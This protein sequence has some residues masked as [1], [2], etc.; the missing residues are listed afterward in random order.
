MKRALVVLAILLAVLGAGLAWRNARTVDRLDRRFTADTLAAADRR[1]LS[2]ARR[3]KAAYGGRVWPGLGRAHIPQVLYDDRWEFLAGWAGPAPEGWERAGDA[4]LF[5]V[6]IRRRRARDP[7][8]FALEVEDR[9]V[10]RY[11]VR[12]LLDRL[13]VQEARRGMDPVSAALV[14]PDLSTVPPDLYVV[15]LLHTAFHAFQATRSEDRF[16][17]AVEL[18]RR[19]ADRYPFGD[20]AISEL[21]TRE[22]A[23]LGRILAAGQRA[24]AC[25]AVEAFRS[26][27]ARRRGRAVLDSALVAYERAQEWLQGTAKYAELAFYRRAAE[28]SGAPEPFG[29]E[30]GPAHWEGDLGLLRSSLGE[31]GPDRRFALSG[32]G[33]ALALQRL[34]SDWKDRVLSGGRASGE[35][36]AEACG[37]GADRSGTPPREGSP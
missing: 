11:P 28:G 34:S 17:R 1:A 21:W 9:W 13:R 18:R 30:R 4:S 15:Q 3:L 12:R 23:A 35:L 27:R 10:G 8:P 5:E 14:P 6:P 20:P 16:H 29:Y 22:G 32:L 25:R 7:Q 33:I 26:A 37:N 31:Q 2:E 24:E 19:S 36:L